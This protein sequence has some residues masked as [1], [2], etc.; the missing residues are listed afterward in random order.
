MNPRTFSFSPPLSTTIKP[1]VTDLSQVPEYAQPDQRLV[2]HGALA[3][4]TPGIRVMRIRI[5]KRLD[6]TVK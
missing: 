5:Y 6:P 3:L 2:L 4:S 1:N